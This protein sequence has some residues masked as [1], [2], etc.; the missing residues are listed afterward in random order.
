[1]FL[2]CSAMQDLILTCIWFY[3]FVC[4]VDAGAGGAGVNSS[5]G[6]E[7]QG[8]ANTGGGVGQGQR[9][10]QPTPAGDGSLA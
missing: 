5:V 1:M 3:W 7:G 4:A 9:G 2:C 8:P 10:V 6:R